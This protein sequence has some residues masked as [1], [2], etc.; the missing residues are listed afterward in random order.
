MKIKGYANIYDESSGSPFDYSIF[1]YALPEGAKG[2]PDPGDKSRMIKRAYPIEI[3]I[4][5]PKEVA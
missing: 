1:I 4:P 3:E 2:V 5:D